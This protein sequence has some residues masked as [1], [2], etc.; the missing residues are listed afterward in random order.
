[1]K[2]SS[3]TR[4]A[5]SGQGAEHSSAHGGR[6]HEGVQGAGQG[7]QS[8]PLADGRHE[9]THHEGLLQ[10]MATSPRLQRRCACGAPSAGDGTCA[11]CEAKTLPQ[12][13]QRKPLTLGAA[14]DLLEREADQVAER[15]L[16]MEVPGEP[17]HEMVQPGRPMISRSG[18]GEAL[19]GEAPTSV[20]AALASPGQPLVPSARAFIE[21]R[22]GL[23]F[24]Q[25]RVHTDGL[26][27]KSARDVHALAYTVGSHVVFG[28]GRYAPDTEAGK[29]LLAHELAHV[30]QQSRGLMKI[31]RQGG[32]P[33]G[34]EPFLVKLPSSGTFL[35]ATPSLMS[36][37]L[38]GEKAMNGDVVVVKNTG[39]A[40]TY[41]AV[42]DG[43]WSWI[44]IPGKRS[45]DQAYPVL[46]GFIES[47]YIASMR[48]DSVEEIKPI[49][50]KEQL[51][52]F[53]IDPN[54]PDT[55]VKTPGYDLPAKRM[56]ILEA[57]AAQVGK[58]KPLIEALLSD[59]PGKEEAARRAALYVLGLRAEIVMAANATGALGVSPQFLAAIMAVEM[60]NRGADV[61]QEIA[62]AKTIYLGD[63]SIGVT[64][65]KLSALA[66]LQGQIPWIEADSPTA[67]SRK[68]AAG[69]VSQNY[70]KLNTGQKEGLLAT[71]A[72]PKTAVTVTAQYLTKLKNRPHRF[73]SY[74]AIKMHAYGAREPAIVATEYN[75]GPT[76]TRADSAQSSD[77]GVVV[78]RLAA[79]PAMTSVLGL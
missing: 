46:H 37:N 26:A 12:D 73:P 8:L 49:P 29:H 55:P 71:L 56:S 23:D 63:P 22:F 47:K 70:A 15:V 57:Y 38:P 34:A 51:H 7:R 36:S 14:D 53:E 27:Q 65:L 25:V 6:H 24:S 69:Q 40:A 13:L 50:Q 68:R 2:A 45:Q 72:N 44:E 31:Q 9:R 52:E 33:A 59:Y 10:L 48:V 28:A 4:H 62:F 78:S 77:Y 5:R 3:L 60:V 18:G 43:T 35:K 41:R 75:L 30:V 76:Q 32:R 54:D 67:E 21:P 11:A 1:M 20:P 16:R 42:K 39:G 17:P 74:Q 64:Q 58:A 19:V 66:M 61:D 79:N